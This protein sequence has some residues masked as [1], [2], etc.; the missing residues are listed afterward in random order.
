M[1]AASLP[2]QP[3][4]LLGDTDIKSCF[5]PCIASSICLPRFPLNVT[6]RPSPLTGPVS[7]G[8]CIIKNRRAN[9]M[10][11]KKKN[12]TQPSGKGTSEGTRWNYRLSD[13]AWS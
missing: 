4:F 1:I 12:K 5:D 7:P 9:L 10:R 11:R 3:G 8:C 2:K 13:A 6:P